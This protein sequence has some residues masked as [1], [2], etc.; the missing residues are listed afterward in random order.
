MIHAECAFAGEAAQVGV[1]RRF[2]AGVLAGVW[3]DVDAAVLLTSELAANAV[4]HSASG[5]PGGKFTVRV[6]VEPGDFMVWKWR[7]RAAP[8]RQVTRAMSGAVGW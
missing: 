6:V 2:V 8:G 3:P 4:L 7:T 5:K 1:A